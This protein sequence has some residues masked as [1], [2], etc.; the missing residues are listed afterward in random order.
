[1]AEKKNIAFLL[2]AGAS[3]EAL[4]VGTE[5]ISNAVKSSILGDSDCRRVSDFPAGYYER[6][7]EVPFS[8]SFER[9]SEYLERIKTVSK[10]VSAEMD[11]WPSAQ[12][13]L[14]FDYEEFFLPIYMIEKMGEE[15]KKNSTVIPLYNALKKTYF[16]L[17]D[18]HNL[19]F[20]NDLPNLLGVCGEIRSLIIDTV[21]S[22]LEVRTVSLEQLKFLS[23]G[24]R[25]VSYEKIH[26]FTLNHDLIID[27]LCTRAEVDYT[28]GFEAFDYGKLEPRS[29]MKW[30][31]QLF[32]EDRRAKLYK[33]HGSINWRD[34]T[35][36]VGVPKTDML[37]YTGVGPF[38]GLIG[39]DE[40]VVGD[41]R[42]RLLLG[43][44]NK[45]LEYV[46]PVFSDL[47]CMFYSALKE[48]NTLIVCGCSFRDLAMLKRVRNWYNEDENRKLVLIDKNVP[49][50][51]MRLLHGILEGDRSVLYKHLPKD[52]VKSIQI[53]D[54]L[55]EVSWPEIRE[56]LSETN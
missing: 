16:A 45:A 6:N 48:V 37:K 29:V 39:T 49:E 30:N 14:E 8:Y 11:G 34:P 7:S 26:V 10:L 27:E 52:R 36:F 38:F 31:A 53:N 50:I 51:A 28:D 18:K 56:F 4:G 2:G 46:E 13:G 9:S 12:L 35:H 43:T 1:M 47:M 17:Y 20:Q 24:L 23:E 44:F 32:N 25:D 55:S 21:W 41:Y 22:K 5:D 54:S 15:N 33:L 42:P 3:Q 40:A 19:H